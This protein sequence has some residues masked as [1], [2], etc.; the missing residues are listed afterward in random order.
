MRFLYFPICLLLLLSA[1]SK[2]EENEPNRKFFSFRMQ[3]TN[4]IAENPAAIFSPPD[5]TDIET[6]NDYYRLTITGTGVGN[7][8]VTFFLTSDLDSLTTGTFTSGQGCSMS[9]LYPASGT[10][11]LANDQNGSF[12]MNIYT[13]KDSI[14][15]ATFDAS[16]IDTTGIASPALA[17]TGFIRAI[18]KTN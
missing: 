4:V 13:L 18:I 14:F 6:S 8:E 16:L 10:F 7:E 11:F 1:C 5:F 12:T 15:E 9:V 2:D 17:T 3:E